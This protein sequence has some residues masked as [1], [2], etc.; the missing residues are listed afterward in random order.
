MPDG[1]FDFSSFNKGSYDDAVRGKQ[2][3][4]IITQVLY[5]N[6]SFYSGKELR[7]KQQYLF[8][9]ASLQDIVRRTLVVDSNVQNFPKHIMIQCNDTQFF[10]LF[11]FF[12]KL[13]N[14]FYFI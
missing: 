11:L 7:L 1:E 13:I 4:E 12:Y 6:D 2:N 14:V 8:V 10:S 5:P 9:S 3:A